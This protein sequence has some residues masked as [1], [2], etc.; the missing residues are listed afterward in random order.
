MAHEHIREKAPHR[1][2][3]NVIGHF[4]RRQRL[5]KNNQNIEYHLLLDSC[6]FPIGRL[7]K[8]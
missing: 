1:L 7:E 2:L 3:Q 6:T 4:K 5:D 8:F